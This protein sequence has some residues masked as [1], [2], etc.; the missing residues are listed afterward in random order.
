MR[1]VDRPGAVL[2]AIAACG[3]PAGGRAPAVAPAPVAE[4]PARAAEPAVVAEGPVRAEEP[5][6]EPAVGDVA[7]SSVALPT[8]A[9]GS[10]HTCV[11]RVDGGVWCWGNGTL[12]QIGDGTSAMARSVPVPVQKLPRALGVVAGGVRTCALTLD[13]ALWCWGYFGPDIEGELPT[14][15]AGAERAVEVAVGGDHLCVRD[16]RGAVRC[17]SE[18]N[19]TGPKGQVEARLVA[20]AGLPKVTRIA[21]GSRHACALGADEKLYCWGENSLGE[22][23]DGTTVARAV[24]AAVP[25]LS[26]VV[27]L[28][29]S[30][31]TTLA[32]RRD[33]TW[34]AFGRD[35]LGG[36]EAQTPRPTP[37]PLTPERRGAAL[38]A[39]DGALCWQA[40]RELV[41]RG[42]RGDV[43][44]HPRATPRHALTLAAGTWEVAVGRHHACA[45]AA[46]RDAVVCAGSNG[47]G[48]LGIGG[49]PRGSAVP[50]TI[51]G[52]GAAVQIVA[53]EYEACARAQDGAV[54]CLRKY[55]T[56]R[57]EPVAGL[58]RAAELHSGVQH[59]CARE[60]GGGVRCWGIEAWRPCHWDSPD[61]C[62]HR[63]L[64]AATKV[65]GLLD[66]AGA[67]EAAGLCARMGDGSVKCWSEEH[68]GEAM[69]L[70]T[71][72][73]V[74]GAVELAGDYGAMCARERGGA[75]R[76]RA[77]SV[78]APNPTAAV[79]GLDDVRQ[80]CAGS[81]RACARR[82]DGTVACWGPRFGEWDAPDKP[83]PWRPEVVAGLEQAVQLDCGLEFACARR[84]DGRALCW[85]KSTGGSLGDG[86]DR[87][88]DEA[89]EVVGLADVV[90]LA[91]GTDFACARR[92]SGEVACWGVLAQGEAF[93]G[94]LRPV[95]GLA[96]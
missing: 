51:A 60:V 14:R 93:S 53:G 66:I 69:K 39:G 35:A 30:G 40:G 29:I 82:G 31:S 91:T 52:F 49:A 22:L 58:G 55:A 6:V 76:C 21:A 96:P 42:L 34:V 20:V 90:E 72:P 10:S 16:D 84:A 2:L 3:S 62:Q 80:I 65:A 5:A 47:D 37:Q 11:V 15:F 67:V 81:S 50:R 95:Y 59:T 19:R 25:G 8:I 26:E 46:G 28:A 61:N 17:W 43:E 45:R 38:V 7:P 33:G 1:R 24:P 23:G 63:H 73:G 71:L 68:V 64:A 36:D 74:Q 88:H 83:T 70:G 89:R 13:R 77:R 56:P 41:C 4:E 44:G 27:A 32:R 57:P 54:R 86:L 92:K 12:G 18:A 78:A 48:Q 75:V 94:A 87:D 85:G 79:P 9:A